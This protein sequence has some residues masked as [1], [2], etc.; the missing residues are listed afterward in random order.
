[1]VACSQGAKPDEPETQEPPLDQPIREPTFEHILSPSEL[2][3]L[4]RGNLPSPVDTLE[5]IQAMAEIQ[6]ELA[7]YRYVP[8]PEVSSPSGPEEPIG[9]S[10]FADEAMLEER[11]TQI[12]SGAIV[13]DCAPLPCTHY[14]DFDG[15]GGR[16]MVTQVLKKADYQPGIF[17]LLSNG[18]YAVLGAG[19]ASEVGEDLLWMTA[20]RSVPA[21][22]ESGT[23]A[24]LILEGTTEQASVQ[25]G[26]AR[27]DGSVEVVARWIKPPPPIE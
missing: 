26:A 13:V 18:K 9:D 11:I 1:M 17:F 27:G 8:S 6:Q 21:E 5:E 15:D 4:L 10:F 23:A 7:K 19:R 20:W 14:G 22:K 16:D 2:M 3:E 25:L 24:N 12:F